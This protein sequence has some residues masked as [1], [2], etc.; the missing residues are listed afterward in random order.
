MIKIG[1]CG[2]SEAHQKYY[3]D[4][5]AL[6]IQETFYNP[7]KISKYQKWKREAP[8]NFEFIVKS[9][10]LITHAPSSPTYRKLKMEIL[11][12]EKKNYGFFQLTTP[13]MKAWEKIEQVAKVLNSKIILFQC[14]ASFKATEENKEN[15]KKFVKK[16]K[17]KKYILV[18]EP[19]KWGEKDIK[20]VCEE[21]G[22]VHVVD[23]FKAKP[24]KGKI[25][26]FRLHGKPGYNLRYKYTDSDLN[27]LKR[28]CDKE[29]NYVMFNNI[30]M[31][32]DAKR[33]QKLLQRSK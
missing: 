12:K 14:P 33:F 31:A 24:V 29:T 7:G 17:S 3:R 9:W 19:R 1:C 22:L 23:P 2:W 8:D 32:Q 10:Q 27:Q 5:G 18:W 28:F 16:I 25:N 11:T 6:E 13:V 26:Y 21:T 30:S 20:E 4:F 15:L